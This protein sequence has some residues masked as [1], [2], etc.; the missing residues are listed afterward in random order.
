MGHTTL[1]KPTIQVFISQNT[2]NQ[3]CA[4]PFKHELTNIQDQVVGYKLL[5]SKEIE[6]R[7][8]WLWIQW[9]IREQRRKLTQLQCGS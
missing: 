9:E 1:P 3:S 5:R 2:G 6:E 7:I 8:E 4:Q